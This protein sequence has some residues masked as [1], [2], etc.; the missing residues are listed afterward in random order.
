V[1]AL[2]LALL[3]W[4]ARGRLPAVGSK[5]EP[6]GYGRLLRRGPF[7]SQA[8]SQAFTLTALLVFVFGAPTVITTTL[9]GKL[10]DFVVMQICGITL[11]IL[12]ANFT[13]ALSNRFG[14]RAM[15]MGGTVLSAVGGVLMLIYASAGGSSMAVITLI[16]LPFN[17][18]LG[19]RGP[20]GFHAALLAS[21]GDD[22]RGAA[23]ILVAIL[24]TTA[25]G[26]AAVAPFITHGLVAIAA[27]AALFSIAA[28]VTLIPSSRPV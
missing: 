6:G 2:A 17:M 18:G 21:G 13:G 5:R 8:L 19:L 15:I 24:L 20:P 3:V 4:L 27:P 10:Q 14:G 9:H 12:A 1:L 11:F 16:F 28:I 22:A 23:L 7:L 25:A 26:T